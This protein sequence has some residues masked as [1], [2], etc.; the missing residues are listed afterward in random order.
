MVVSDGLQP[1]GA[2]TGAPCHTAV[3]FA[4]FNTSTAAFSALLIMAIWSGEGLHVT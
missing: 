3:T 4:F 2:D 1:P